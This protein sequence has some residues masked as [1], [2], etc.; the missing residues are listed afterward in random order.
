MFV[1]RCL[2]FENTSQRM[3]FTIIMLNSILDNESDAVVLLLLANYLQIE[4]DDTFNE[5]SRKGC[6]KALTQKRLIDNETELRA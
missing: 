5:R 4:N 6:I 3:C 2:V 1:G